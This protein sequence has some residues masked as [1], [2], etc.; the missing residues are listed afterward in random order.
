MSMSK[1]ERTL[2]S[3]DVAARLGIS[4]K[5][6]YLLIFAGEFGRLSRYRGHRARQ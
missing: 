6:V 5:E 1:T 3:T 4:G 2:G